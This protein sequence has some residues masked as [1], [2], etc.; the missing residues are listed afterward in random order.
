M[1][2]I[3]ILVFA[4]ALVVGTVAAY[5]F[6]ISS[7]NNDSPLSIDFDF[8]SKTSPSGNIV[9]EKRTISDFKTIE[10]S[11]LITVDVVTQKDYSLE[12]ETDDNILKFIKTE[13]EDG[14]L[15]I[16]KTRGSFK[17][18]KA[19]V[20]ISAPEINRLEV[21]GVTKTSVANLNTESFDVDMNG[22][23]KI[24]LDGRVTDLKVDMNGASK[25]EA[26]NLKAENVSIEGSG[27]SR[28]Y[29]TVAGKLSS[30]LSGASNV[31]YY[32]EPGEIVKKNSGASSLRQLKD[33]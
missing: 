19:T 20:R 30:D 10:V 16:Y 22:A 12:I 25:L 31:S 17:K 26:K 7:S 14:V 5:I 8:G 13:V 4:F 24:Q 29:V 18:F 33:E 32:G 1:K 15:K 9:T 23:S 27:A 21:S 2:K 11:G 28:A 3:G 6:S